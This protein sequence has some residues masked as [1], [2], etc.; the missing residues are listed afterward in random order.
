M[1]LPYAPLPARSEILD[2]SETS[3]LGFRPS[4]HRPLPYREAMEMIRE[5]QFSR[6]AALVSVTARIPAVTLD[7]T[8]T[9]AEINRL[10]SRSGGGT[11][12][13]ENAGLTRAA[14]AMQLRFETD[15]GP[16]QPDGTRPV[17]LT[18]VQVNPNY[19][20]ITQWIAAE[21][22]VDSCEYRATVAHED[23]HVQID[24][25]RLVTYAARMREALVYSFIPTRDNPISAASLEAGRQ[26]IETTLVG[27]LQPIYQALRRDL[28]QA[29]D[30]LDAPETYQNVYDQCSNW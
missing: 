8:L 6:N 2:D 1:P 15:E 5:L 11:R 3:T 21:Y 19:R 13:A 22:A 14:L 29:N 12:Q 20:S 7:H 10:S 28:H 23:E 9:G 18:S 26:Q 17:W 24:R 16:A 27:I 4:A 30:D 25:D